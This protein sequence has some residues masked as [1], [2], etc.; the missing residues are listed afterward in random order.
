VTSHLSIFIVMTMAS[1]CGNDTRFFMV[2]DNRFVWGA[3]ESGNRWKHRGTRGFY[4]G[5]D[6]PN[7]NNSTSCVLVYY[8]MFFLV[9]P[10]PPFSMPREIGF[11]RKM[12]QLQSY[13]TGGFS[14]KQECTNTS[15]TGIQYH[16]IGF[17]KVITH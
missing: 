6:L 7:D 13:P 4:I 9:P 10:T 16:I 5:S 1:V 14:M 11:T 8:D 17:S 3:H 2:C 15:H 12:S